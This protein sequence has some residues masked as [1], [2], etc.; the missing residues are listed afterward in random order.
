MLISQF[1]PTY[2]KISDTKLT[3][4]KF[5]DKICHIFELWEKISVPDIT[6]LFFYCYKTFNLHVP[7]LPTHNPASPVLMPRDINSWHHGIRPIDRPCP[8]ANI[9]RCSTG[10]SLSEIAIYRAE[11]TILPRK[12]VVITKDNC[13][14]VELVCMASSGKVDPISAKFI[15]CK[16]NMNVYISVGYSQCYIYDSQYY[17]IIGK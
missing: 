3:H 12:L 8:M 16:H 1:A 13:S 14:V 11:P 2:V 6:N 7:R 15:P 9:V 17:I 10:E 4:T 5:C